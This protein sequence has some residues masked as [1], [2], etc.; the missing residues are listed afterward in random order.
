MTDFQFERV[1]T[2]TGELH[3]QDAPGVY[4]VRIDFGRDITLTSE[5]ILLLDGATVERMDAPRLPSPAPIPGGALTHESHKERFA[6]AASRNR[7]EF[8]NL[9]VGKSAISVLSRYWSQESRWTPSANTFPH[10]L[11]GLQ[12]L[13][14]DGTHIVDLAAECKLHDS[15]G[16]D[17][18]ALWERE[19][20]PGIYYLR[21]VLPDGRIFCGAVVAA[22]DWTTQVAIRRANTDIALGA[23][24][25][26]VNAI[27]DVAIFM[28]RAGAEKRP[29]DQDDVVEAARLALADGRNLFGQGRGAYLQELLLEKYDDPVARIIGAHLLLIAMDASPQ[30]N[31]ER[32]PLFDAVVRDLRTMIAMDHPDVEALSLRCADPALRTSGPF[33]APPM[34]HRS[35]QL[36]IEASHQNLTLLPPELWGQVHASTHAGVFFVWASDDRTRAAHAEQLIS[37]MTATSDVSAPAPT[38]G[39]APRGASRATA[40]TGMPAASFALPNASPP[41]AVR[42]AAQRSNIPACALDKLWSGRSSAPSAPPAASKRRRERVR[43]DH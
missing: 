6:A 43:A 41:D 18:V 24:V 17:P 14:P 8:S 38:A 40:R 16:A 9:Q 12:L 23:H 37:W 30:A 5:R 10:P 13:A 39:A 35:W 1:F 2:E 25:A 19:L 27:G 33:T 28:R 15:A 11:E 4:K 42:E 22:A 31:V 32:A 3:E 34:F 26:H 36:M 29:A 20:A 7:A 21:Q